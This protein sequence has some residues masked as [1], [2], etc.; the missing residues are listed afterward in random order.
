MTT[1]RQ[2]AAAAKDGQSFDLDQARA[3]RRDR[4]GIEFNFTFGGEDFTCLPIKEWGLGVSELL[5]AGEMGDALKLVLGEE[6][7]SRFVE[8]GASLGDIEDLITALGKF[9]GVGDSLGE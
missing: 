2:K 7:Y 8:A 4:E 3:I 1:P 5:A 6:P 9:G